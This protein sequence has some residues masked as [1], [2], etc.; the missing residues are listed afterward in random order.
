ME[1]NFL[2]I[3]IGLGRMVA[4]IGYILILKICVDREMPL[5]FMVIGATGLPGK[6]KS[7]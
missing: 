3:A 5:I 7:E 6:K 2:I 4:L 1:M